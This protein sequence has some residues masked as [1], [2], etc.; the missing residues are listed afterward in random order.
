VPTAFSKSVRIQF[1]DLSR[2]SPAFLCLPGW[3]ENKSAFGR[4]THALGRAQRVIALDW[5]G[6]GKSASAGAEFGHEELVDDAL[7]VIRA[8]SVGTV[9]P[10]AVSH[11]GWVALEL[12]R[13]LGERVPRIVVLDW[14][15]GPPPPA[16]LAALAALQDREQWLA[17]RGELFRAWIADCELTHV[18]RHVREEMGSY[19]FE[20]WARAARA[21]ESAYV[22]GAPLEALARLAPP[23]PTVHLYSQPRDPAYLAFQQDFARA[24]PWFRV[25]RLDARSHFPALEVPE[26]VARAVIEFVAGG[27]RRVGP[28]AR[29]E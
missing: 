4:V 25:Q 2:G 21:I 5:R 10:V 7:S 3:C 26:A 11:A 28:L 19:G 14:I 20:M 27:Q 22:D 6:H 15:V 24:H 8:S 16:F 17:T 1:N 23:C 9:V 12:R 29:S 18:A 13:R